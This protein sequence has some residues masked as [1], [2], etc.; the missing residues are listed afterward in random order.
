MALVRSSSRK[1]SVRMVACDLD[2]TLLR[3]DRSLSDRTA[4]AVVAVESVGIAVVLVTAR[5]PRYVEEIATALSCHPVAVC[6]NGAFVWE[7]GRPDLLAEHFIPAP[8]GIEA[9]RR[10]RDGLPGAVF[11]V[12]MGLH[13]Y[14][15]EPH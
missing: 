11:S 3:R 13:R 2:G 5:P 9:V 10:L 1:S 15:C 12:E 8:V 6:S 14:G 7:V 4:A